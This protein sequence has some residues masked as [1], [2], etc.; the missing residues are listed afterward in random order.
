MKFV[1]YATYV[2]NQQT[3]ADLRPRHRQYL[4]SLL[5]EGKLAAAGL[6]TDGTGELFVYEL[7]SIDAA[8][9]AAAADPFA[10]G[11][12]LAC[13][14]VKPWDLVVA[15]ARLVPLLENTRYRPATIDGVDIFYREAGPEDA[16]VLLLLHGFPTSSRM[17]RNLVPR[18]SDAYRVIAP[19]Y[20]G[21]GHSAVPDRAGF[22]YTFDHFAEVIDKLL[23]QLGIRQFAMYV[24]DF[25]APVGYTG[26]RSGIPSESPR[27]SPRTRRSTR[28]NPADGG[29]R[30]ASTGPTAPLSTGT[31]RA[32][33]WSWTD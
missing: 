30:S 23:D 15:G 21:F 11:G 4:T 9:E 20:P 17:F 12:A 33:T 31:R 8:K 7:D 13:Y 14:E 18:L 1:N 32:R 25:G 27:S 16:P 22:D 24:M 2:D 3:L 5:A 6:F 26:S 19:D 28:R 10:A 29:Q